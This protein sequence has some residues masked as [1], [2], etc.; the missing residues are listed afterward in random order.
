MCYKQNEH[1]DE[2]R[3]V[4]GDIAEIRD[5]LKSECRIINEFL[6]Q[7]YAFDLEEMYKYYYPNLIRNQVLIK[8]EQNSPC[9]FPASVQHILHLKTQ[10]K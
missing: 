8:M 1:I 9:D 6:I 3:F 5:L 4:A 10:H 7:Y 2:I